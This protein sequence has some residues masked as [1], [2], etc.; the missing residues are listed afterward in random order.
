[1]DRLNDQPKLN[2]QPYFMH[3]VF[4]AEVHAGT[5]NRVAV[6]QLH[7]WQINP[8]TQTFSENFGG[9]DFSHAWGG[10]PLI[11]M[12]ARILGV[13]TVAAGGKTIR[14]EPLPAGLLFARGIVPTD[15]GDIKVAWTASEGTFSLEVTLPPQTKAEVIL[16][17]RKDP[18][19]EIWLDGRR[20][21]QAPVSIAGGSHSV[22]VHRARTN[23]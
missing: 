3:F 23:D 5:F 19:T 22:I 1:M 9:G 8:E 20:Q 15:A 14:I 6:H 10:T 13:S 11:Q 12:S 2:V 18:G 17:G 21:L 7:L 16:P 4:A